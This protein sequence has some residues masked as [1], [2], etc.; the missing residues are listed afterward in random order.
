MNV[1][2]WD[3]ER[4]GMVVREVSELCRGLPAPP[5]AVATAGADPR[6]QN[7]LGRTNPGRWLSVHRWRI[8]AARRP[9]GPVVRAVLP[10]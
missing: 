5:H 1:T 4:T 7:L 3:R 8:D 2:L 10:A 9:V 6:C